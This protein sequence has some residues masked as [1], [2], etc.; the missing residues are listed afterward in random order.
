MSKIVLMNWSADF[1][2]DVKCAKLRMKEATNELI[3]HISSLYLGVEETP[4]K[5]Y[6][7]QGGEE[8]VKVE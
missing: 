3:S 4:I 6:V 8:I 2:M 1:A 7:L 5:E